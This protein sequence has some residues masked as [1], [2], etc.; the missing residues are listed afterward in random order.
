MSAEIKVGMVFDTA[1][2]KANATKAAQEVRKAVEQTNPTLTSK[3]SSQMAREWTDRQ[4]QLRAQTD[5]WMA[6]AKESFNRRQSQATA[7]QEAIQGGMNAV[8]GFAGRFGLSGL[9]TAARAGAV[10]IAVAGAV[11]GFIALT[12]ATQR[13]IQAFDEAAGRYAKQLTSGLPGGFTTTRSVLAQVIGVSERDVLQY[14]RAIEF[15][16][17]RVKLAAAE[18]NRTTPVLTAVSWNWRILGLDIKAAWAQVAEAFAPLANMLAKAGSAIIEFYR[19]TGLTAT[20]YTALAKALQL[21]TGALTAIVSVALL[22]TTAII[23]LGDAIQYFLRQVENSYYRMTGQFWKISDKDTFKETKAAWAAIQK[24]WDSFSRK[25]AVETVPNATSSYNR[26]EASPW[27]RMGLIIG[28]SASGNPLS[29][30]AKNTKNTVEILKKI[31][32]FM[33]PR[34][35]N[36]PPLLPNGSVPAL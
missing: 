35:D 15:L 32:D 31:K 18:L 4:R 13:V 24:L 16:N 21:V 36:A 26:L 23:A 8:S 1:Q 12:K 33:Q 22:A 11:A 27:E 30:T 7:R 28:G 29:E 6:R 14:G 2:A 25:G 10:G 34:G 19:E 3:S 9:P 17:D 20:A 5:A